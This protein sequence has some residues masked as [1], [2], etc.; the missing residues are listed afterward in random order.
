M[1]WPA[2]LLLLLVLV[3]SSFSNVNAY[4]VGEHY[5]CRGVQ[6]SRPWGCIG[7]TSEFVTS[8]T[9]VFAWAKLYDLTKSYKIR[10]EWSKINELGQEIGRYTQSWSTTDPHSEGHSSYD[11]YTIW[12]YIPISTGDAIGKWSVS[13]SIDD[14]QAFSLQ[15]TVKKDTNLVQRTETVLVSSTLTSTVT[16]TTVETSVKGQYSLASILPFPLDIL[17]VVSL[18]L[19]TS[20]SAYRWGR[21]GRSSPRQ[22]YDSFAGYLAKLEELRSRN[23]ISQVTYERLKDEYRTQIKGSVDHDK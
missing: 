13:A 15:F 11:W 19:I 7:M 20:Y 12:E 2:M 16:A 21:G 23:E 6:K 4:R 1:K 22:Q 14:K 5:I 8:D 9:M 10:F 3:L 17:T 18:I